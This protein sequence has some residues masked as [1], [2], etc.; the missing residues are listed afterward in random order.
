MSDS[1]SSS[2]GVSLGT[3]L[4][5]I[6]LILKLVGVIDWSWWWVFSPLLI[7]VGFWILVL[8]ILY[9]ISSTMN[10]EQPR[11]RIL[12]KTSKTVTLKLGD[13]PM[14]FPWEE[15]N[16]KL[17]VVDKVWATYNEEEAKRQAEADDLVNDAVFAVLVQNGGGDPSFKLAHIAALPG[18]IDKLTVLLECNRLEVMNI[19]HK[20]L[21]AMNSFM[22]KPMF[23]DD[24]LKRNGIHHKKKHLP[25]DEK[26]V[27]VFDEKKP[28][29]GD[30]F[31]CLGELKDKLEK[32]S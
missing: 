16:K 32:E 6:F 4:F 28:T 13:K 15:F 26:P 1:S 19:I 9:I 11:F 7:G 10:K 14:T 31:S 2:S 30:A 22:S 8:I 12:N 24:E 5:L 3:V 20:R 29:L 25:K 21:M 23:T 18:I 27:P 17:I